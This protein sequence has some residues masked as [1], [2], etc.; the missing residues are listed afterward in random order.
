MARRCRPIRSARAAARRAD[1]RS[2]RGATSRLSKTSATWAKTRSA[3]PTIARAGF[4]VP[5]ARG[6]K[7]LRVRAP[8]ARHYVRDPLTRQIQFG[9]GLRGDG[10]AA[11]RNTVIAKE[12]QRRRRHQGNVNANTLTSLTRAVP[13]IEKA[14]ITSCRRSAAPMP[15]P[16]TRPK[17]APPADK[18][19]RPRRHRRGT[20]R[21]WPCARPPASPAPRPCR[22]GA[23]AT[24]SS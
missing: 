12:S 19:P 13:Y 14:S 18:E 23:A 4:M 6:R 24:S 7:L 20:S 3:R 17:S 11:G 10:P 1:H 16:W 2:A 22:R 8:V 9:D 15:R 21:P 5:L